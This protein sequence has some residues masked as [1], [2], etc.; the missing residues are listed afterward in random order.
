[1]IDALRERGIAHELAFL[2]Q[3]KD[4]G[5]VVSEATDD[6]TSIDGAARTLEAMATGADV[7]YQ[8]ALADD[9]WAGRADFL[10]KVTAPSNLGAWSYEVIDTKLAQETKAGTILQ[11]CIYSY[12]LGKLQGKVP[13]SMHVVT[14][15]GELSTQSYRIDDYAAYFRLLEQGIEGFTQGSVSTYPEM[16]PHCDLCVWWD[17]C[18]TRR[19]E[20][21]HLGYVAG[22][23]TNQIQW[24]KENGIDRLEQLA[25]CK[26]IPKPS[27]GS[28]EALVRSRDQA[29]AQLKG[30]QQGKPYH[31]LKEP[32]ISRAAILLKTGY[33]ST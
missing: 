12:L 18:E 4:S 32:F 21:D 30:R 26:D 3:L 5:L 13:V 1:M 23:S 7:I 24:L 14:P 27:R 33:K 29:R 9:T 19:R 10:H 25:L 20:D 16:V 11:L 15:K 28:L 22:I 6:E 17:S 2:E 31:K 8:A